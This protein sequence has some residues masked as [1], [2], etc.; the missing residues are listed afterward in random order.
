MFKKQPS[1]K[2]HSVLRSSDRKKIIQQII[3][4]FSLEDIDQEAKNALLPDGAQ[5]RCYPG[6][7]IFALQLTLICFLVCQVYDSSRRTR[8]ALL[9]L[10]R[11][12]TFMDK[13]Y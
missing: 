7:V 12:R 3:H 10:A 6:I 5:V 11:C 9:R 13:G 2:N 1:V 4:S 8:C